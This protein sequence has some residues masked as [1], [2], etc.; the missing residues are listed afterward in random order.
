MTRESGWG[1]GEDHLG[2]Q[3]RWGAVGGALWTSSVT[4]MPNM[5]VIHKELNKKGL[6]Q[7]ALESDSGHEYIMTKERYE[8]VCCW[9]MILITN[10]LLSLHTVTINCYKNQT[11]KQTSYKEQEWEFTAAGPKHVMRQRCGMYNKLWG[12]TRIHTKYACRHIHSHR[13]RAKQD[14]VWH[15]HKHTHRERVKSEWNHSQPEPT[16]L[17]SPCVGKSHTRAHTLLLRDLP[18]GEIKLAFWL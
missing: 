2:E 8:R 12:L 5:N 11:R 1:T 15:T 18:A 9:L 4:W 7:S 3:A 10:C 13:R 17:S 14:K 6:S 16:G